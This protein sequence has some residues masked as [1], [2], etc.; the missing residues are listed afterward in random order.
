MATPS[1]YAPPSEPL[2]PNDNPPVLR[3]SDKDPN[4]NPK[5]NQTNEC[6]DCSGGGQNLDQCNSSYSSYPV[7]FSSGEIR[8][9]VK[10]LESDGFGL[11]WV[12]PAVM[13]TECLRPTRES[14]GTAGL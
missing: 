3:G 12:I 7:R 10:D 4:G 11:P 13:G 1:R 6:Q 5:D 9:V 2:F 8:L 14:T